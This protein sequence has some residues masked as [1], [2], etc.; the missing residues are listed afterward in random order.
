MITCPWCG[1]RYVAFQSKC[2]ACGG[3]L[4]VPPDAARLPCLE[5]VP[6]PPPP[7]RSVPRGYVWRILGADAGSIIAGILGFMGATSA[8]VGAAIAFTIGLIG[9]PF[10]ALGIV[11]LGIAQ[12]GRAHV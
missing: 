12:I 9:W 6:M 1:T 5:E 4:P 3:S 10:L 11:F 8:V 7:P 2:S